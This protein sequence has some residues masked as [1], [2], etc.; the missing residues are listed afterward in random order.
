VW[1]AESP[2]T[3]STNGPSPGTCSIVSTRSNSVIRHAYSGSAQYSV[4]SPKNDRGTAASGASGPIVSIAR[5]A[6][7]TC[8]A[9]SRPLGGML[10]ATVCGCALCD[11]QAASRHATATVATTATIARHRRPR[12]DVPARITVG[13]SPVRPGPDRPA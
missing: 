6:G 13:V 9:A 11:A 12:P 1:S 5:A 7:A 10:A 8:A 2:P 3:R 4:D